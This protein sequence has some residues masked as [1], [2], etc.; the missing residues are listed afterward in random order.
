L[1]GWAYFQ[2]AVQTIPETV[3]PW[4]LTF[5]THGQSRQHVN[6]ALLLSPIGQGL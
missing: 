2:K 5:E 3:D 4:T 6:A 1:K